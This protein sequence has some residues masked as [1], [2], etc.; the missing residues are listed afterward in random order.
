MK[1]ILSVFLPYAAMA[2]ALTA[3]TYRTLLVF[4]GANGAG[5]QAPIVRG[6]DGALYGTTS[7]G[8]AYGHGTVFKITPAGF[9]TL[10]SFCA[11][12]GCPDGEIITGGLARSADGNLYGTTYYG[13]AY[14]LGSVFSITPSGKLTTSYSF[15][16]GIHFPCPDGAYPY[17]GVVVSDSGE[18]YG[19]TQ[20]GGLGGP[21][22]GTV[23]KMTPS[24]ALTTLYTFVYTFPILWE[25]TVPLVQAASEEFYGAAGDTLFAVAS[26]GTFHSFGNLTAGPSSALVQGA[27]G[28]LYGTA[29]DGLSPSLG[30]DVFKIS[31]GG[32]FTTVYNFC[33]QPGCTDGKTPMGGL[34]VGSDGNLYGTTQYGGVNNAGTIFKITPGGTLTTL[35]S[36]SCTGNYC[37]DGA[38]PVSALVQDTNG[39]FYGTTLGGAKR[40]GTIFSLD[41]GLAPFVAVQPAAGKSGAS[42][43]ILGSNL[44]GTT[45]VSFDGIA[46]A[47]AV[48]SKTLITTTVPA[49]ATTGTVQVV[50]P[51]GTLS[52]NVPFVVRP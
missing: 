6:A 1:R 25:P 2:V 13:G 20:Y 45:S 21:G 30:G 48:V 52:S 5:P 51:S 16:P 26:T 46:A 8:G 35:H 19:V 38:Y 39:I 28:S 42:V 47:F 14:G 50:T 17:A 10:Y 27:D 43:A 29:R 36:F 49:G 44:Q 4:D 32:D 22:S 33:S 24:G 12:S 40:D 11:L 34:V 37:F 23:F 31:P 3:Q 9:S 41:V 18:L 7:G 15:C